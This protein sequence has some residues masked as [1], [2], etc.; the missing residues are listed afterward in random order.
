MDSPKIDIPVHIPLDLF[1]LLG[2]RTWLIVPPSFIVHIFLPPTA[3]PQTCMHS[4]STLLN[5][6]TAASNCKQTED[7]LDIYSFV[8]GQLIVQ[9]MDLLLTSIYTT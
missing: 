2:L 4:I 1:Y 5:S 7:L 8:F 6:D 9:F 3:S